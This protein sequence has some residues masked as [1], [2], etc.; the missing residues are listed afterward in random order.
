MREA[1]LW[2]AYWF[3]AGVLAAGL[4]V[5][6]ALAV[7]LGDDCGGQVAPGKHTVELPDLDAIEGRLIRS[8]AIRRHWED[9]AL[10]HA[11]VS[12]VACE[13][14]ERVAMTWEVR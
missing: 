9:L 4:V 8:A 2:A 12:A 7:A 5:A 10:R 11:G 3:F 14:M 6:F 1:S 13:Q